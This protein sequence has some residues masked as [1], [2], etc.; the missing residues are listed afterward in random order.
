LVKHSRPDVSR[1]VRELAK[2]A[3]G[4]TSGHWK[5]MTTRRTK[6]V[7]ILK[8]MGKRRKSFQT[9]EMFTLEGISDSEYAED[10]DIRISVYGYIIYFYGAPIAWKPKWGKSVNLSSTEVEY[11]SLS[12]VANELIFVKQVVMS[13]GYKTSF[14]IMIKVNNFGAIYVAQKPK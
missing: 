9:R 1:A 10:T 4:A 6:C 7:W 13:M 2:V 5:T 14:S 12:E 11:F 8:F 3:D